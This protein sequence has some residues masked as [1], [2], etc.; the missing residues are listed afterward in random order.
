MAGFLNI[1]LER[2]LAL[3]YFQCRNSNVLQCRGR[4]SGM[5]EYLVDGTSR[6]V[7]GGVTGGRQR[8]FDKFDFPR[9]P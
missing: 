1:W 2:A 4:A 5:F 6:D 7:L 9:Y 8:K 3:P